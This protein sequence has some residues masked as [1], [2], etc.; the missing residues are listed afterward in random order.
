MLT[1]VFSIHWGLQTSQTYEVPKK[2]GVGVSVR[3]EQ[4]DKN[5]EIYQTFVQ[6]LE[7][8]HQLE[9]SKYNST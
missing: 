8:K 6:E 4:T 5:R 2:G 7:Y 9:I 3:K 1:P